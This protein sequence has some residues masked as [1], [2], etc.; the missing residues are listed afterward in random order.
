M[1]ILLLMVSM[2]SMEIEGSAIDTKETTFRP[3]FADWLVGFYTHPKSNRSESR[4]LAEQLIATIDLLKI[5]S[6]IVS[7]HSLSP[8]E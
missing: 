2:E 7:R 3:P 5:Q 6:N 4:I 8:F 1:V